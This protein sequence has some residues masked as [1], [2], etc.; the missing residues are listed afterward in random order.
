MRDIAH[1]AGAFFVSE[2][3]DRW[4]CVTWSVT[5]YN[6]TTKDPGWSNHF[7]SNLALKICKPL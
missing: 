2:I 1:S 5:G 3:K 4:T 6:I 7:V